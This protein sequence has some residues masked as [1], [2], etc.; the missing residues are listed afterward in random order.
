[1]TSQPGYQTIAIH[2][3]PNISESKSKHTIK[4]GQLIVHKKRNIFI[5]NLC[6]K[7]GWD[8]SSRNLLFLK[9]T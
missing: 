5:Q 2:V 4:L 7:W 6:R 9:N 8:T 3:L 1:M